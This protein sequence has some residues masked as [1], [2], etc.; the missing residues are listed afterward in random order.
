MVLKKIKSRKLKRG[1]R[2]IQIFEQFSDDSFHNAIRPGY[3]KFLN[4]YMNYNHYLFQPF[5]LA[6]ALGFL[7]YLELLLKVTT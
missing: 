4:I 3:C 6:N 2:S 5:W 1:R 7:E